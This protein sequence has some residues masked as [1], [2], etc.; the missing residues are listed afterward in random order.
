MKTKLALASITIAAAAVLASQSTVAQ[1]AID[2]FDTTVTVTGLGT[3]RCPS[4]AKVVGGGFKTIPSNYYGSSSSDE[5]AITGSY[6]ASSTSWTVT[7]NKV[8]GTYSSS[9]GW[10]FSNVYWAPTA[11]AVCTK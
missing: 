11:V 2:Y 10:R 1:S 8:H 4:G 9:N 7:G 3:A 6:A 5:Y